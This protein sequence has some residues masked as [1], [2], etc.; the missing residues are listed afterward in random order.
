MG[1]Q[2]FLHALIVGKILSEKLVHDVPVGLR[3]AG[4]VDE[5]VDPADVDV[6]ADF[7]LHVQQESLQ[8]IRVHLQRQAAV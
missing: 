8:Q 3:V 4:E 6:F 7:L 1:S 2:G 5:V